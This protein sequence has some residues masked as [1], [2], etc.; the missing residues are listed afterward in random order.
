MQQ[1]SGAAQAYDCERQKQ[2]DLKPE[3]R[4]PTPP[5]SACL[6]QLAPISEL[7]RPA[8]RSRLDDYLSQEEF[9][10]ADG[11]DDEAESAKFTFPNIR[12]CFD[13]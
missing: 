2:E 12:Y 3:P 11:S 7:A 4:P 9:K 10:V 8:S 1:A 13:H 5:D 6:P